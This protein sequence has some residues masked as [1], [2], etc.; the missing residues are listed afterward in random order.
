MNCENVFNLLKENKLK[1]AFAESITGGNLASEFVKIAGASNHFEL[2][3]VSY[4][5]KAKEKYLNIDK[6]T[7]LKYGVVSREIAELMAINIKTLANS[8][9]GVG[10]TGNAGPTALENSKVG[11]V[12][13]GITIHNKTYNYKMN[14]PGSSRREVIKLATEKVWEILNNLLNNIYRKE[15][16]K[17]QHKRLNIICLYVIIIKRS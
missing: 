11:D 5:N 3:I 12:W 8:D 9:I 1:I 14:F 10:I 7:L 17:R 16:W 2:G 13:L 15:T 4:S 6:L